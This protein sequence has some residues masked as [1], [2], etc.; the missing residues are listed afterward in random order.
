MPVILDT[1]QVEIMVQSQPQAN[2][3]YLENIQ[4]IKGLAEWLKW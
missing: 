2:R 4:H 1:Q 3:G